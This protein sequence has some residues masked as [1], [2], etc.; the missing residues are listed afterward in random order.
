MPESRSGAD[1]C[2]GR[3]SG[4]P[5]RVRVSAASVSGPQPRERPPRT[6]AAQVTSA[7]LAV[8]FD[9]GLNLMARKAPHTSE[10]GGFVCGSAMVQND[11]DGRAGPPTLFHGWPISRAAAGA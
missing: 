8:F 3:R 10:K 5:F 2:L 11:L 4:P 6:G 1:G 9:H 7:S